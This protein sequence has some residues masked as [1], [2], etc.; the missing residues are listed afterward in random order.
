MK[1]IIIIIIIII[2][3]IIIIIIMIIMIII[4]KCVAEISLK[5]QHKFTGDKRKCY[6]YYSGL[7][8]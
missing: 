1:I 5:I 7:S 8:V 4:C 3:M 6:N 2:I